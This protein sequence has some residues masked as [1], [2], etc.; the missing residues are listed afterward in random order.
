MTCA[1]CSVRRVSNNH[2]HSEVGAITLTYGQ[3]EPSAEKTSVTF[4]QVTAAGRQRRNPRGRGLLTVHICCWQAM[5]HL[6]YIHFSF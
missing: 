2:S 6:S 3:G 5:G 1:R 4:T